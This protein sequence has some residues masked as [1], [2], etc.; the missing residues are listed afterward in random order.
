[1]I[2]HIVLM[3]SICGA[4]AFSSVFMTVAQDQPPKAKIT[5]T[6]SA[7]DR[8]GVT[9]VRSSSSDDIAVKDGKGWKAHFF[10]S[11]DGGSGGTGPVGG[12]TYAGGVSTGTA[13]V[14]TG[15]VGVSAGVP[16]GQMDEY[17]SWDVDVRLV[18]TGIDSVT[19]DLDWHRS[20]NDAGKAL[21]A[22]GDHRTI[23]LRQGDRH[24]LDFVSC[25]P[26]DSRIANLLMEIQARPVEDP[27]FAGVNLGY[28]LWLVQQAADG[29]KTTRHATVKGRQG[30]KVPFE[31]M[32]VGFPLEAMAQPEADRL[33]KMLVDG[34]ITG[35]VSSDGPIQV[36]LQPRLSFRFGDEP[37]GGI[38][39]GTK[40]FTVR[41]G[42]AISLELP[43]RSGYCAGWIDGAKIANPAAGVKLVD[44]GRVEIDFKQFLAGTKTSILLTVRR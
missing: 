11:R 26:A 13:G 19:F 33:L 1:M 36:S 23:M 38:G 32:P 18:S 44:N 28:D 31:F 21:V 4:L 30:E 8:A 24:V 37:R 29:A 10:S 42:E 27:E 3:L 43:S 15:A 39:S 34:T 20:E 41:E 7:T 16:F 9:R 35:R 2:R 17:F 5:I 22:A 14:S 25:S 12:G 6:L 40:T